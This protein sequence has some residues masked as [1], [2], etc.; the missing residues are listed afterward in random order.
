MVNTG[1]SLC[2]KCGGDLKYYDQVRRIVRTKR[3]KTWRIAMRRLRCMNCGALH[4]ELPKLIF[5]YKQ[6]EA[7]VIT[8]VLDGLI[9]SD[10][11]GYENYPSEITMIRWLSKSADFATHIMEK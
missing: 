2:P 6:Y 8:G 11:L 10:T 3:R 1:T 4:R 5:P 7:D 9:T